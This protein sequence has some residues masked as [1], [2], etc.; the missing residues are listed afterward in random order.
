MLDVRDYIFKK[1]TPYD[2]DASFLMSA[3]ERTEKLWQECLE[4]L[5]KEAKNDGVLDIDT[6]RVS[7]VNAFDPGYIDQELEVIV[8]LQTNAPLKRAMKPYGGIRTVEKALQERGREMDPALSETF[9]KY[10]TTHNDGVFSAY[11]KEMRVLRTTGTITGLQDNYARGRII[12]DYRRVALYGVD[13]LIEEKNVDKDALVGDMTDEVIRLRE[14][15]NK[16]IVSLGELKKMAASHG[17]DI[18]APAVGAKQA[19][20]WTYYA[21]LG[22]VKQQDGAAMS[23]GNVTSF[24]DTYIE[25]DLKNG[26]LTEEG[27]QELIDQF[28]IKLRLVRHLRAKEYDQ[29]FAGDPTWVTV[30][31]GGRW[32]DGKSKVTKT[33]FRFLQTLYNLGPAPEPNLTV[34]YSPD[35]PK[36]WRDFVAQVSIDTSSIQYENDDLMVPHSSD[37]YGISCCVSALAQGSEIQYFGARCNLGKGLLLALNEGR[38]ENTGM[39]VVPG[40][41]QLVDEVL[42]YDEVKINFE[43][44]MDYLTHQYAQTLNLIHYMH[45]KYYYESM[46]MALLDSSPSRLMAFGVAGMSVAVD[47][48]SAI[49]NAKVKVKRNDEGISESFEIEGDYP[50]YGND[51]DEVDVIAQETVKY[52]YDRLSKEYIYRGAVPTLSLLTITSNVFYGKKTGATP[53]GRKAGEAFAPGANPMHGRDKTGAIASLNSVAKLDYSVARDGISNTFTILPQ[54]LGKDKNEQVKNLVQLLD[55]YMT[56]GGHHLNINVF[57]KEM[58][59]DAMKNPE[60]YPQ[61]TIR[62]SGYAVNFNRLSKMQQEEVLSRTFHGG[63]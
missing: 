12:G 49:K 48:L 63:I 26:E 57:K 3:T 62:V 38:D 13:R 54:S 36:T 39:L 50:A 59:E 23:L 51:N 34:L 56:K 55:G 40:I 15:I 25:E 6:D 30:T 18:S 14:E 28:V 43:K 29:I 4:L 11:T 32:K 44:V 1:I 42:N 17:D 2:G 21:Y 37:D 35:L 53:D 8:G 27:A 31:L 7:E 41:P 10:C 5:D 52:F 61:L 60:K 16:Q 45:D 20:Q 24:F 47:S 46:Q 19:I 9:N 58:L 22:A 33:D